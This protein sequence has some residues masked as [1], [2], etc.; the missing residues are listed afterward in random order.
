M[1]CNRNIHLN[2]GVSIS[3]LTNRVA[4]KMVIFQKLKFSQVSPLKIVPFDEKTLCGKLEQNILIFR[5]SS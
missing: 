3:L 5:G 2:T 4:L 1:L